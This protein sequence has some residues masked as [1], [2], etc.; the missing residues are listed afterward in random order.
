MDESVDG[1]EVGSSMT[2]QHGTRNCTVVITYIMLHCNAQQ[3]QTE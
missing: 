3:T 2:L 1:K